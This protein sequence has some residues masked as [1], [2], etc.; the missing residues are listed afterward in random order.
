MAKIVN[1]L[2]QVTDICGTIPAGV[3]DSGESIFDDGIRDV[4]HRFSKTKR[5]MMPLFASDT[6][7]VP[8]QGYSPLN[9]LI[10]DVESYDSSRP[11]VC[12]IVPVS[13]KR[14]V[15]K[16][17]NSIYEA[18]LTSPVYYIDSGKLYTA[19]QQDF[20]VTIAA[21]T[22][23][24]AFGIGGTVTAAKGSALE[25]GDVFAVQSNQDF[26]GTELATAKGSA[27]A[28]YDYFR[29]T[30]VTT[31]AVE[32][33]SPSSVSAVSIGTVTNYDTGTSSIA[34]FPSEYYYLPIMYTAI[35]LMLTK[36][37]L[38]AEKAGATNAMT[39]VDTY[40]ENLGT[41]NDF[42]A[43]IADEDSEMAAV[44]AQG[45]GVRVG[46]ARTTGEL[47]I[48]D[49]QIMQQEVAVLRQQYLEAFVPYG[50]AEQRQTGRS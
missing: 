17:S 35:S 47:G 50:Q 41:D 9:S 18:T 14:K 2:E 16:D 23:V 22:I 29:I 5:E 34:N 36:I 39:S 6:T 31:P 43:W 8:D 46:E 32:Y 13:L 21:E 4:I 48:M 33:L 20:D 7:F 19:P 42:E 38:L 3:T 24:V 30:A 37:A 49:L 11:Y 25:V 10:L 27:P 40:F 1:F 44:V 26:T 28:Q 45:A 15:Q 12:S